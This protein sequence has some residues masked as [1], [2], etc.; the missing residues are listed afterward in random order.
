MKHTSVV[1]WM[2]GSKMC[3][4]WQAVNRAMEKVN[5]CLVRSIL[6]TYW[7]NKSWVKV[8]Q[9]FPKK[10]DSYFQSINVSILCS[11]PGNK[12]SFHSNFA[13]PMEK[14]KS[15][16]EKIMMGDL[17]RHTRILQECR[18]YFAEYFNSLMLWWFYWTNW[19][20]SNNRR[21][22]VKL[23]KLYL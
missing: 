20:A 19:N 12:L 21:H 11:L 17:L 4:I 23:L 2:R 16:D 5:T 10:T 15:I 14:W 7:H 9:T 18:Q 13:M 8:R 6:C 1:H 3:I 22:F